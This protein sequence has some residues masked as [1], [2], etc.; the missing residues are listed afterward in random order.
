[1]ATIQDRVRDAITDVPDFPKPGILFKDITPVC[2][3]PALFRDVT[4]HFAQ[5]WAGQGITHVAAVESRGFVFG[6][7]L[8][9]EMGLPLV[10]VRKPGKLPRP[11]IS[12]TYGLEYGSDTLHIHE[13]ALS[14]SDKVLVIDDVLATGGTARATGELVEKCGA[15]V[16]GYA[17]LIELAFLEGRP[18]L[19][20]LPVESIYS[21]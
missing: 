11:T 5:Q 9:L 8:A 15:T 3:D 13:D 14:A 6:A 18:K 17:F 10:I 19:G 20:D 7:P 21:Y 16:G 2:M 12:V 1:M 4:R